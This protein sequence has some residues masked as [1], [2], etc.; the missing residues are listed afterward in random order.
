MTA[1]A[2]SSA[3][4]PAKA[5]NSCRRTSVSTSKM[6]QAREL[7]G[8][9]IL[10]GGVTSM[11][12]SKRHKH[13]ILWAKFRIQQ[14]I[15]CSRKLAT[16]RLQQETCN[17]WRQ[18][19]VKLYHQRLI[20]RG[21]V[22]SYEGHVNSDTRLLLGVDPSERFV[23]SGREDRNLRLWSIKSGKLLF[24]D[25]FC[26]TIPSTVCWRRAESTY[27]LL[28]LCSH[29]SCHSPHFTDL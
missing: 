26:N 10:S 11:R 18:E 22:Q 9:L 15:G 3:Q 12:N 16:Y 28:L 25:K 17:K 27:S 4:T 21:A 6:L 14:H 1:S 20:Q 2:S 24:E 5:N 13:A 23:M 19:I 8:N 29:S 7:C